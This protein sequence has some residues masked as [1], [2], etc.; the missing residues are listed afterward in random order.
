MAQSKE[1]LIPIDEQ[2]SILILK[3]ETKVQDL[4]EK[5]RV[6]ATEEVF[7]VSTKAGQKA[8]ASMAAKVAKC[9]TTIDN[10][11]KDYV[12]EIK[13]TVK[14]I[15]ANRKLLRDSLDYLKQEVRQPLNEIEQAEK[16]RIAAHE[17][18]L[19][20]I[21]DAANDLFSSSADVQAC[22]DRISAIDVPALEEFAPEGEKAK[23]QTLF[24][25][26]TKLEQ[27]KQQEFQAA[28]LARLEEENRQKDAELAAQKAAEQARIDAERDS[29]RKVAEAE[30][31]AKQAEI[32]AQQA[33][34]AALAKA[35]AE[36]QAE[37]DAKA[38]READVAHMQ[39]INRQV[40]EDLLTIPTINEAQAKEVIRA[41]VKGEIKH[42]S[43]NY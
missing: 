25:L 16:D 26:T 35:E 20:T 19:Q 11:G 12:G 15:D 36:R 31:A 38:K 28:E 13:A 42:T 7:D 4:L 29:A 33:E 6:I 23:K 40:L 18:I 21:K 22:I 9:K 1:L 14:D 34:Q 37:A 43:I 24:D 8:C 41:I 27:W 30:E 32:R 17:L 3:D 10:F 5:I 2:S 39:S